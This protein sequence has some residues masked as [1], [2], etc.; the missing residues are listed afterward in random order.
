MSNANKTLLV[1]GCSY[2]FGQEIY[3][4][5]FEPGD[6]RPSKHAWPS[7]YA[8]LAKYSSVI[9]LALPGESNH[10]IARSIINKATELLDRGVDFDIAV[11][12]TFLHR[13]EV[14]RQCWTHLGIW[15]AESL[16]NLM[17]KHLSDQYWEQQLLTVR[18]LLTEFCNMYN[19]TLKEWFLDYP[20]NNF[21]YA[22]FGTVVY[23]N[24]GLKASHF[25]HGPNGHPLEEA[26]A[27][28]AQLLHKHWDQQ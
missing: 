4:A 5:V 15:H 28:A 8:N 11:M 21:D 26:Q 24:T 10:Y 1:S 14:F 22:L 25:P 23:S 9:N 16:T 27:H 13:T 20:C 12:W 6:I 2:T 3:D 18:L 17:L 7:V 19:I